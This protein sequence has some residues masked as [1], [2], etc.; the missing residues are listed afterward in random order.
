MLK[1]AWLRNWLYHDQLLSGVAGLRFLVQGNPAA[2]SYSHQITAA[3][4]AGRR[5]GRISRVR[6]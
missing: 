5:P 6:P 4:A 3:A 2:L 1:A